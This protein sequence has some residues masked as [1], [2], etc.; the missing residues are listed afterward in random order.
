MAVATVPIHSEQ[1]STTLA[2]NSPLSYTEYIEQ[3]R[4]SDVKHHFFY[5]EL[6]EVAGASLEHNIICG[7]LIIALG[8]ALEAAN[9]S[10]MPSDMKVFV[11]Q[12]VVYYPDIVVFCAEP[13]VTPS[14]AL[15]NP[16]LIV[17]ILSPSTAAFDRGDKFRQYR[18]IASLRHYLLLEQDRPIIEHY[19]R[20][21]AGVWML[22]GE[23]DALEQNLELTV[24]GH[25]IFVPIT[26]IYRNI[27]FPAVAPSAIDPN[28]TEE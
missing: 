24:S 14:E 17:E 3:E 5:G 16:V 10:V 25:K 20:D 18:T 7:N 1:A 13:M 6:I 9:C 15:Q 2:P 12:N 26:R 28:T 23:Y 22:R 11:S 27:T 19:E 4:T 21:D 8:N